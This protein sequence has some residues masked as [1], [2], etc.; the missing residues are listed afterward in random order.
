MKV[1]VLMSG[2]KQDGGKCWEINL[3]NRL[4]LLKI[5]MCGQTRYARYENRK[6]TAV[7]DDEPGL[8]EEPK[9]ILG[10]ETSWKEVEKYL[11]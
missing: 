2:A 8:A 4:K 9:I 5:E 10:P 7:T 6:L 1:Y 11:C 3:S